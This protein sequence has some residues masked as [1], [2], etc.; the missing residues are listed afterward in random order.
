MLRKDIH[1]GSLVRKIFLE[2]K[3]AGKITISQFADILSCDRS[4]IYAI[5]ENKSI[6]TD[7]L[8]RISQAL[9]YNFLQEYFEEEESPRYHLVI[10]EGD[11]LKIEQIIAN[12]SPK[13]VKK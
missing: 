4:R 1:I 5:F 6:D 9:D 12:I 13:I 2:Q 7:M 10:A 11:R 3:K 8:I